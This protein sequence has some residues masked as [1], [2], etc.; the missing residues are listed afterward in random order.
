MQYMSEDIIPLHG[1]EQQLLCR[2]FHQRGG[3]TP[4]RDIPS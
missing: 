2:V 4:H 3:V 1:H